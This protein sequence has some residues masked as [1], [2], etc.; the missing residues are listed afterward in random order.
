MQKYYQCA[1]KLKAQKSRKIIF[2]FL[3]FNLVCDQSW[4]QPLPN[5]AFMVGSVI[6]ASLLGSI[7]DAIGRRKAL[8]LALALAAIGQV[9]SAAAPEFYTLLL[10]RII[11]GAGG[12]ATFQ[13]AFIL[14]K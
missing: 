8:V 11:V 9:F 3:Q 13:I 10:S 14:C 7:A 5:V 2:Y 4:K 12:T 6:G 1:I